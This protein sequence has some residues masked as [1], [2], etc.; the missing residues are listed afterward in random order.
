MC[1]LNTLKPSGSTTDYTF[2]LDSPE[3]DT[4]SDSSSSSSSSSN[5]KSPP[6]LSPQN[7]KKDPIFVDLPAPTEA[8]NPL[9]SPEMAL[10]TPHIIEKPSEDTLYTQEDTLDT[11]KDTLKDTPED[12]LKDTLKDTLENTEI[13]QVIEVRKTVPFTFCNMKQN[14]FDLKKKRGR[15]PWK[16]LNQNHFI[17]NLTNT[18]NNLDH[19]K[20]AN[21]EKPCPLRKRKNPRSESL[22]LEVLSS[23]SPRIQESLY[24][25]HSEIL[26][27]NEDFEDEIIYSDTDLHL[28]LEE[29]IDDFI[30]SKELV[31]SVVDNLLSS[32][33]TQRLRSRSKSSTYRVS[34]QMFDL[35]PETPL[36][37]FECCGC[38]KNYSYH[39]SF[40][41]NLKCQT[42]LVT[43]SSCSWWTRRSVG[44]KDKNF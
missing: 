11:P 36:T 29:D 8:K 17:Q 1:L 10:L 23:K 2:S 21:F 22:D 12:T 37:N 14:I 32:V 38:T 41:F 15:K 42:M 39:D 40:S 25:R 26:K 30:D 24:R 18:A 35:F 44:L 19:P 4:T 9:V 31:E 28:E 3:S 20:N 43:C 27:S 34:V 6:Q 5:S 16:K 33:V 13:P 7:G